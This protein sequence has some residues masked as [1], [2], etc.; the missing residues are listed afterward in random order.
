MEEIKK[1]TSDLLYSQQEIVNAMDKLFINFKKDSKDRKTP[2][3]IRRKLE[4][5][6]MYWREFVSNHILIIQQGIDSDHDY[7]AENQYDQAKNF[8][9]KS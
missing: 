3:Y 2:D 6:E 1:N 9:E 5:L 7:I 4:T 8:Y